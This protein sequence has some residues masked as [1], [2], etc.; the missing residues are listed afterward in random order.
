MD[1]PKIYWR[2]VLW[3]AL[4]KMVF[5]LFFIERYG[6][7]RDELLYLA[8][9]DHP[10]AG[11]WSTPPLTGWINWLTQHTLG[12]ALWAIRLPALVA[13]C[14]LVILAG[15]MA[16]ELGG[17]RYA[18]W[19]AAAAV[20]VSP[21]YLRT[22][23][24]FMP[25]IF[26][27][28]FWA[29][30][31][32]ILLRYLKTGRERYVLLFGAFWGLG[33]L[34]KYSVA[35]LLLALLPVL[36]ISR[37]RRVLWSP[38]AAKAAGLALLIILPNLLWQYFNNFPVITHMSDLARYQLG[39]VRPVNFLSDQLLMNLPALLAW[40]PGLGW[41]L[42]ASKARPFRLIGGLYL[43][44]LLLF[45]L[46][47][48]KSYYTLG[49]YPVLMAAGGVAWESRVSAWY[50]RLAL[51]VAMVALLLPILPLGVPVLPMNQLL[52]Y[53]SWMVEKAGIDGPMRWEDGRIHPVPQDYADMHGWKEIAQLA[54]QAYQQVPEGE[55]VMIYGENY[56]Q[57]GAVDYYGDQWGLPQAVSFADSYRLWLPEQPGVD[58]LIYINDELGQDVADLFGEVRL[59]GQVEHP[60]ARERGTAVYLCRKPRRDLDKFWAERVAIVRAR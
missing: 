15:L 5:H 37:H 40:L 34:N 32:W 36:L 57:A 6:I 28:L 26:D 27:I 60:L 42:L 9:G 45:I 55:R 7:H 13:G 3:L 54:A 52:P 11:F 38:A 41:F 16:R 22:S 31:T 18:Q 51:P 8:L 44:V 39:N 25:V 46:L 24:M 35:F 20:V 10:D 14:L 56:G 59:I 4:S 21:A 47:S 43:A 53:C 1:Q 58:G 29:G 19:L 2:P 33:F 50:T 49:I 23:Q 30:M 17:G 12:D 48:G